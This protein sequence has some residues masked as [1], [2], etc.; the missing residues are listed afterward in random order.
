MLSDPCVGAGATE[1]GER[2]TVGPPPVRVNDAPMKSERLVVVATVKR[3]F[4]V[5]AIVRLAADA[6]VSD[7][8]IATD[9]PGAPVAPVARLHRLEDAPRIDGRSL[10]GGFVERGLHEPE[11]AH[12]RRRGEELTDLT[13][14]RLRV[15]VFLGHRFRV[16]VRLTLRLFE[17]VERGEVRVTALR[18][19]LGAREDLDRR[20]VGPHGR[21]DA[22]VRHEARQRRAHD[23]AAVVGVAALRLNLDRAEVRRLVSRLPSRVRDVKDREVLGLPAGAVAEDQRVSHATE[24]DVGH[25]VERRGVVVT[26]GGAGNV[27]P[28]VLD[29]PVVKFIVGA[30]ADLGVALRRGADGPHAERLAR[31]DRECRHLARRIGGALTAGGRG[32]S[33]SDRHASRAPA[34]LSN[35]T[36][37]IASLT[38]RDRSR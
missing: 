17:F 38:R 29:D 20:S 26:D 9:A 4:D 18:L 30:R 24:E 12:A 35:T 8:T 33:S 7:R 28:E 3:L 23:R 37:M 2:L 19:D 21:L 36:T 16:L 32:P 27:L 22:R 10:L 13:L 34:T 15:D 5:A 31:A 1:D 14:A 6:P 25:E 11:P